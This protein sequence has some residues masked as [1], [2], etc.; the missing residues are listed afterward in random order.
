MK[1]LFICHRPYHVLLSCLIQKDV[2]N[3]DKSDF[4]ILNVPELG[5]SER[6]YSNFYEDVFNYKLFGEK[7]FFYD[8]K[9]EKRIITPIQFRLYYQSIL[10][11]V[12]TNIKDDY[13]EVYFYSDKEVFNQVV[14]NYL[15]ENKRVGNVYLVDEGNAKSQKY[16]H[17]MHLKPNYISEAFIR[18]AKKIYISVFKT[19]FL[20]DNVYYGETYLYDNFITTKKGSIDLK[21]IRDIKC[22]KLT[23]FKSLDKK[24]FNFNL[25]SDVGSNKFAIF[26]DSALSEGNYVQIGTELSVIKKIIRLLKVYGYNVKYKPHPVT[27]KIKREEISKECEVLNAY[28]PVELIV[29]RFSI[30][31][32]PNSSSLNNLEC[33]NNIFE[34][35]RLFNLNFK[36]KYAD[37]IESVKD[38][39]EL[40]K[41]LRSID[42]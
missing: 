17:F 16:I 40:E 38:L 30:V 21:W 14:I 8:K 32:S 10:E 4:I 12:K 33:K 2:Y 18:L 6:I 36:I 37:W 7:I 19:I 1:R 29:E 11:W 9:N 26:I 34:C 23:D 42:Y 35:S 20:E 27:C 28:I 41:K 24:I 3:N 31:L 22:I 25:R 39:N 15:K 13:K 5:G